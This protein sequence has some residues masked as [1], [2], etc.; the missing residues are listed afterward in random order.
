[1]ISVHSD[2]PKD[3]PPP[4]RAKIE[5]EVPVVFKLARGWPAEVVGFAAFKLRGIKPLSGVPVLQCPG[6]R[7]GV[8]IPAYM[9]A[10]SGSWV[11]LD[12]DQRADVAVGILD[13]PDVMEAL[14]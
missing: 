9:L 1:M 11:S 2:W 4:F 7:K 13:H 10:D 3:V 14:K 5:F 6:D 8:V 12:A